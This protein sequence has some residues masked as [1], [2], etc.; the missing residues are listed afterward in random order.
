MQQL[1]WRQGVQSDGTTQGHRW[2]KCRQP[3]EKLMVNTPH[4]VTAG[5]THKD[6]VVDV[7]G[8]LQ[9]WR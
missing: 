5:I 3:D 1:V 4:E 6:A 9:V 8:L 7:M 2:D